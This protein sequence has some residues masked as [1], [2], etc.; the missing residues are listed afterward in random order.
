MRYE[1]IRYIDEDSPAIPA[2][3][4]REITTPV[5]CLMRDRET[6]AVIQFKTPREAVNWFVKHLVEVDSLE[7]PGTSW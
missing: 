3:A 1:L 2:V 5:P 4:F 7:W 6:H